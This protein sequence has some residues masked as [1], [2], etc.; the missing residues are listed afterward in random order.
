MDTFYIGEINI[1]SSTS[2]S[3]CIY[4]EKYTTV[5]K[6]GYSVTS[7]VPTTL[8]RSYFQE[9]AAQHCSHYWGY[10]STNDLINYGIDYRGACELGTSWAAVGKYAATKPTWSTFGAW[11]SLAP[12]YIPRPT[13]AVGNP[14]IL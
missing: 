6:S 2:A 14:L 1:V 10:D 12:S 8:D 3:A 5:E 7:N 11:T 4:D 9:Y 13:V